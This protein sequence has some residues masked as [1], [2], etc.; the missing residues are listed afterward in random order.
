MPRIPGMARSSLVAGSLSGLILLAIGA[1]QAKVVAQ[2]GLQGSFGLVVEML[3]WPGVLLAMVPT[4]ALGRSLGRA[5]RGG[6]ALAQGVI[7]G[8]LA[9][10]GYFLASALLVAVMRAHPLASDPSVLPSRGWSPYALF[11]AVA[12]VLGA[13]VT[14]AG[15]ATIQRTP[16]IVRAH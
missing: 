1:F 6:S 7:V 4:A 14:W 11:L 12:C 3:F 15:A 16:G 8:L 2:G 5:G 10:V 13:L 9:S